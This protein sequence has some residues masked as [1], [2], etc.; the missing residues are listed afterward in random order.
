[1]KVEERVGESTTIQLN[2]KTVELPLVTGSEGENGIDITSLRKETGFIT[3]D[4]GY[5]NT[6]ACKSSVCFIDGEKGILRY[7]GI[8]IEQLAEKSNFIETTYLL[9]YGKLPLKKEVEL[10]TDRILKNLSLPDIIL[11]FFKGFAPD[12][13]PMAMLSAL[14][15]ALS[16]YDPKH[17]SLDQ[18]AEDIDKAAINLIAKF[19]AL[20]ANIYRQS[21]GKDFVTPSHDWS[22]T[23][24]L[25]HM[26][27]RNTDKEDSINAESIH[28]L[29]M[30]LIL[31]ADHEQNC[32]TSAVQL[33]GSSRTNLYASIA[34]GIAALWGPWHG[35]ANQDVMEML[36]KIHDSGGNV[37]EYVDIVKDKKSNIRLSGFGHRVYKTLDP[38]AKVIKSVCDKVLE[39]MGIDDPL[40]EIA[41]ELEQ[42]ALKDE[43]FIKRKLYP[44]VDFYSGIIYKAIGIPTNLFTVMFAMGR[45]PGWIA[46]WKEMLSS[47]PSK[48]GRPRQIYVGPIKTDYVPIEERK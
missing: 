22:Y 48:I 12:T 4:P 35:G 26:M 21:I 14:V 9:L 3:L 18:T 2:G 15:S 28:A 38:R 17:S 45:L 25:L 36:Q 20:V 1:M 42:T 39:K 16:G 8:P 40:L 11:N 5:G 6:G 23:E 37:K 41:K 27:F 34:A 46:H 43:Y 47:K 13:H 30:L 19:P 24:N 44:N 29:D 10:L 7:R 31:H 32:S 33:V